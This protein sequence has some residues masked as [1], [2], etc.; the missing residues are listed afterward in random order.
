MSLNLHGVIA[1][2]RFRAGVV[3]PT[4]GYG[5]TFAQLQSRQLVERIWKGRPQ[6]V[7]AL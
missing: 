5:G 6:K 3:G 4:G 7:T 2:R 1:H